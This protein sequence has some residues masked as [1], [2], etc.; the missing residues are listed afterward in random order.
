MRFNPLAFVAGAIFGAGLVLSRLADPARVIA[1]LDLLAGSDLALPITFAMAATSF[2]LVFRAARRYGPRVGRTIATPARGRI[3]RRL[4]LG[5]TL[6]GAGWGLAGLCPGPALVS[7]GAAAPGVI[8]FLPAMLAG[9]LLADTPAALL[10]RL[11][12]AN[13][14]R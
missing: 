8:Y 13:W 6:F 10:A 9:L 4:A 7:L 1:F 3:D 2:G 11:R 12:R 14:T 5:A